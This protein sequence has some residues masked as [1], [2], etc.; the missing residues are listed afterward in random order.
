MRRFRFIILALSALCIIAGAT[1]SFS[2]S[3]K[4]SY[5]KKS[6]KGKY[7]QIAIVDKDKVNE[8]YD[9][10]CH[11]TCRGVVT[12]E[13]I[14]DID[15]MVAVRETV[16]VGNEPKSSKGPT[17]DNTFYEVEE[18][19]EFPGGLAALM[20]WLS[21]NMRYPEEA[22]CDSIQG[23][24]IVRFVVEKNGAIGDISILKSIHP[25]LDNEAIRIVKRMPR[26]RPGKNNGQPVRS[27]FC[28]PI[29]FRLT[30]TESETSEG[31]KD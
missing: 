10:V 24:V 7:T 27:Q 2:A 19:A 1:Y 31:K 26:W 11:E 9:D 3:K 20:K 21:N 17:E 13:G 14:D 16:V 22:Q 25:A 29:T 30:S 8:V 15:K 6:S 28:L 18:P 12:Q 23:R 5:K 4:R